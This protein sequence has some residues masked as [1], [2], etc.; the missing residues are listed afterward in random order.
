MERIDNFLGVNERFHRARL[1]E[2]FFQTDE[3]GDLFEDRVWKIR[4]GQ[5]RTT[6]TTKAAAVDTLAGFQNTSGEFVIFT[7][8][9]A[10]AT[11]ELSITTF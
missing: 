3:G 8:V 9:G 7:V 10:T 2:G 1:P 4:R 11:S 5:R 6:I